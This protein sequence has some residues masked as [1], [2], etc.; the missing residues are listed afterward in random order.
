MSRFILTLLASI[1]LTGC[2]VVE[3][4]DHGMEELDRYSANGREKNKAEA[5][6]KG[7]AE[8]QAATASRLKEPGIRDKLAGWWREALEEET[9]APDPN[10][11]IVK[12]EYRGTVRFTRQSDCEL[13][14]GRVK[15][16]LPR[17][18]DS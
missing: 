4:L 11:G 6:A 8:E 17:A 18:K 15:S 2:F 1:A 7:A 5:A 16:G 14:G 13:L 3:E 10:D 9:V 12:C